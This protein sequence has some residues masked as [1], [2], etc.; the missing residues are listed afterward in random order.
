M[1]FVGGSPED[2]WHWFENITV[3]S[4]AVFRL[5]KPEVQKKITAA[6]IDA[7]RAYSADGTVSIPCTAIM[8]SA[9]KI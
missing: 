6:I 3:R 7:A 9:C 4:M 2:V 1:T 8:Y 5:Q